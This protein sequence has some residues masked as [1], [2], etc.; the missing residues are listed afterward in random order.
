MVRALCDG[1]QHAGY[2]ADMDDDGDIW[3]DC[4]DG[5]RYF[6]AWETQPA[7]EREFWLSDVCPICQDFEGYGLGVVLEREKQALE[8]LYEYRRQVAAGRRS[9]F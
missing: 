9:M 6:D 2:R 5:D 3:F 8:E 7:E 1:L 4:D